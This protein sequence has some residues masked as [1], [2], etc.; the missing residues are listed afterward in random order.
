MESIT[1]EKPK[2]ILDTKYYETFCMCC[3]RKATKI[4]KFLLKQ[5]VIDRKQKWKGHTRYADNDYF[6]D[7][8]RC[9]YCEKC[10]RELDDEDLHSVWESRG[11]FWGAPCSENIL[12]GYKCGG[13]GYENKF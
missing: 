9:E 4:W 6:Y 12:I 11:E 1:T 2:D 8:N 10:G 13:C 5:P 7:T 3:G